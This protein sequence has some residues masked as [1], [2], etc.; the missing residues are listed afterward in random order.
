LDEFIASEAAF[1]DFY[2]RNPFLRSWRQQFG[3][4]LQ[5]T[6]HFSPG[7]D[8]IL[9]ADFQTL[10]TL[11]EVLNQQ[12][13]EQYVFAVEGYAYKAGAD[14]ANQLSLRLAQAVVDHLHRV[15]GVPLSRLRATSG[16]RS[17]SVNSSRVDI[18]PVGNAAQ[19]AI[20]ATSA[21]A[22][23]ESLAVDPAGRYMALGR[24]PMEVWDV[25][26]EVHL[27]SLGSCGYRKFSPNGHYLACSSSFTDAGGYRRYAVYVY[28]V[29]IGLRVVTLA[30]FN[31]ASCLAWNPQSSQIVFTTDKPQI[32]ILDL[33]Q[34]RR[35]RVAAIPGG[36]HILSTGI[37][38][39]KDGRY[40][41][42]GLAQ[43]K[44]LLV[45]NPADLTI[46]RKLD[47]IN[48]PHSLQETGDGL[49][50]V[51][52]DN[53]FTISV[54]DEAKFELRQSPIGVLSNKMAAHPSKPLVLLDDF[55]HAGE[56]KL[57]L[58]DVAK[59]KILASRE[60]GEANVSTSFTADGGHVL[61]AELNHLF[62][63]DPATL[64][65]TGEIVG[66]AE[67][68]IA[69]TSAPKNGYYLILDSSGVHVWDV[70]TGRKVHI[71]R[72]KFDRI[73]TLDDEGRFLAF[74]GDSATGTT[75]AT[76]LDTNTFEAWTWATLPMTIDAVSVTKRQIAIAGTPFHLPNQASDAG[77]VCIYDLATHSMKA[78]F[79]VPLVTGA[80]RFDRIY[81]SGF[82]S[83]ALT[84][85][86]DQ[87]ALVTWWQDGF[88]HEGTNSRLARI[89]NVSTGD[90][91]EKVEM[92]SEVSEVAFEGQD[93]RYFRV[94]S[95]S[96][97]STYRTSDAEWDHAVDVAMGEAPIHFAEGETIYWAINYLRK[98][99]ALTP[100]PAMIHAAAFEAQNLLV[101]LNSRNELIFYDLKTFDTKLT[102]VNKNGGEWIAYAPS[103][104]F[105]SSLHGAEK[106]YWELGYQ[107]VDFAAFGERFEKPKVIADRLRAVAT[108]GL[109]VPASPPAISPEV[110]TPPYSLE[111]ISKNNFDTTAASYDLELRVIKQ[112]SDLPDPEIVYTQQGRPLDTAA[113]G[114]ST[115]GQDNHIIRRTFDLGEGTNV[116]QA[117]IR[118]RS[119]IVPGPVI[120]INRNL[121]H[122]SLN[123]KPTSSLWFF[124]VGI[125]HYAPEH[126][127][128]DLFY[129]DR[130]VEQ[131]SEILAR[132]EG[133]LY[134][135]VR[136]KL[137]LNT[138]AR[139]QDVRVQMNEFLR[140]AGDQDLVVIMLSAHGID[141]NG[142]LYLVTTDADPDQPYTGLNLSEIRNLVKKRPPN[143]KVIIWIDICHAG[144]FGSGQE[145]AKGRVSADD[146]IKELAQGTGLIVL[147][148]S[149]AS[150]SSLESPDYDG[151]HGAFSAALIEA[152][153]GRTRTQS[154]GDEGILTVLQLQ[155]YVASR[156][157]AMTN[158]RQHPTVPEAHEF[159]DFPIALP[160]Y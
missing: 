150:E 72:Q 32:I 70:T 55:S 96:S 4:S 67:P 78:S 68:A 48:W 128:R 80:L 1:D 152:L 31:E 88:G 43:A 57:L 60:T 64:Q 65:Q 149:T 5:A 14:E 121:P 16:A 157:P 8:D 33:T 79:S 120:I 144:A 158:G 136:S 123:A 98:S 119:A 41:V 12:G 153:S 133:K 3:D 15:N 130:D 148:S 73:M 85:A 160:F 154:A 159:R 7:S 44:E 6:V 126:K 115:P 71:W 118:F 23:E 131:V 86:G 95:G 27:K 50:L 127:V 63:L 112:S 19:P 42:S 74:R 135:H 53:T 39:T 9:P 92:A 20:V 11:A 110:F 51:C 46:L 52:A 129:A 17:S 100:M 102:V 111:V 66:T 58:F 87:V 61:S 76:V 25:E 28:D 45:W 29:A 109:A 75:I 62:V 99:K 90:L 91:R 113:K 138:E 134:L 137:M 35:V 104:E 101:T 26:Q 18:L 139:A 13:A 56:Q 10:D 103:G 106:V 81:R 38:W 54:W 114:F 143:Q 156:V 155:N 105:A 49:Y 93:D 97:T 145:N 36:M 24:E 122:I 2:K 47:G 132:Q 89:F 117:N 108:G 125:S 140:Q 69:G 77:K 107:Y 21:L 141:D 146:A 83:L 34:K 116:I 94:T 37:V 142:D 82:A 124:G 84:N 59:M 22:A 30:L 40:I 147:A 151:G